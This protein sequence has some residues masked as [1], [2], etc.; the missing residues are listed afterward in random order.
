MA[1]SV[2]RG[3]YFVSSVRA[4]M[5]KQSAGNKFLKFYFAAL[6]IVVNS[7]E[8]AINTDDAARVSCN[9]C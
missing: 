6:C 8:R 3:G 9:L 5:R 2:G 7:C 4:K 1:L